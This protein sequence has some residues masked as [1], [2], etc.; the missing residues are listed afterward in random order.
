MSLP[1]SLNTAWV[2]DT[3]PSPDAQDVSTL[4][5]IRIKFAKFLDT[6]SI[7]NDK[8]TLHCPSGNVVSDAFETINVIF[9]YNSLSRVLYL[10]P[11]SELSGNSEYTLQIS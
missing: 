1:K 9:D 6:T 4:S 5:A 11:R 2:A 7:T 3:E 10:K 8:F